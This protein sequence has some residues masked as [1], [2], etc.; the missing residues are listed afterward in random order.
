LVLLHTARA[1]EL[2]AEASLFADAYHCDAVAITDAVVEVYDKAALLADLGAAASE[3]GLVATMARQLQEAR[4]RLELR[5]VRSA[6][7]RVLLW[8]DLRAGSAREVAVEGELQD[9]AAELGLTREA[10]YRTLAALERDG[11]ISREGSRIT[12]PSAIPHDRDHM[13]AGDPAVVRRHRR[14]PMLPISLLVL[15]LM[16][17]AGGA[18]AQHASH[19]GH[20]SPYAG[21]ESRAVKALSDQQIADLK[22]GRGMGLALAAELNGYPGPLHV[23]ELGD[24]L[25]LTPEQRA[26]TQTLFDAMRAETVPLGERIIAQETE[27]DRLFAEKRIDPESLKASTAAIGASQGELRAAHLRYHLSTLDALTPHQVHLYGKLRG[28]AAH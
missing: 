10:F 1:G 28:Y 12:L 2:F 27:L 23:L 13:L 26:K 17:P 6:R 22:A 14:S 5:N 7:E 21:M 11:L 8:L 3:S 20:G 19:H 9:I 15:A 18:L 4:G 16:L 24:K 25:A